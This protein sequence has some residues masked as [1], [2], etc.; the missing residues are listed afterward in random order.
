MFAPTVFRKNPYENAP[1]E[2]GFL[3]CII[4]YPLFVVCVKQEL[5]STVV[6]WKCQRRNGDYD[7]DG[8]WWKAFPMVP[9]RRVRGR[10][11]LIIGCARLA[12]TILKKD[13]SGRKNA[14]AH[15][16][17]LHNRNK[18]LKKQYLIKCTSSGGV[19]HLRRGTPL[20]I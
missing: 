5:Y 17:L 19:G 6:M 1:K 14:G 9:A 12:V 4:H 7:Y 16:L 15:G 2:G 11:I 18:R 10:I 3:V 20:Y 13:S 8:F